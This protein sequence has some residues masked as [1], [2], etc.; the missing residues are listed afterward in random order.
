MQPF[1]PNDGTQYQFYLAGSTTGTTSGGN[2]GCLSTHPGEQWL[3]INIASGG[4]MKFLTESQA[5]HDYA[6]W[7]PYADKAAAIANCGNTPAPVDCSFDPRPDES[8]NVGNVQAGETYIILLTNYAN[9][10][11]NLIAEISPANTAGYDCQDNDTRCE[12]WNK[13]D[14]IACPLVRMVNYDCEDEPVPFSGYCGPRPSALFRGPGEIECG[15]G[16]DGSIYNYE[17]SDGEIADENKQYVIWNILPF[18]YKI[19][20]LSTVHFLLG[21]TLV[22]LGETTILCFRQNNSFWILLLAN[23]AMLLLIY[24]SRCFMPIWALFMFIWL[25]MDI[26]LCLMNRVL[27]A[28]P[29]AP[30]KPTPPRSNLE[31]FAYTN[32]KKSWK[33]KAYATFELRQHKKDSVVQKKIEKKALVAKQAKKPNFKGGAY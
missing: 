30:P 8:H 6:I 22:D 10:D 1:C 15:G 12:C 18:V 7:G 16:N 4:N 27:N 23:I 14:L 5:D 17:C 25:H 20:F 28:K 11:Q 19:L 32:H 26:V 21:C 29:K 33:E 9:I 24:L 31:L 2:F 13:P 3:Y